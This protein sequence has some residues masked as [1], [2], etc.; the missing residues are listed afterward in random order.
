VRLWPVAVGVSALLAL[1]RALRTNAN[2]SRLAPGVKIA[3][4]YLLLF[5]VLFPDVRLFRATSILSLS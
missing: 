3:V 2:T 4:E 1:A 5:A